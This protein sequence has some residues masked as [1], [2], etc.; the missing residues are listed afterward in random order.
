MQDFVFRMLGLTKFVRPNNL[1]LVKTAA[2]SFSSSVIPTPLNNGF[3]LVLPTQ[4]SVNLFIQNK[5][6]NH[7]VSLGDA[8][9]ELIQ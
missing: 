6:I 5:I 1:K 8:L 7:N 4:Q 3:K 9:L 2:L